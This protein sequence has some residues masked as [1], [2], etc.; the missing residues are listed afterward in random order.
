MLNRT[1]YFDIIAKIRKAY[2][3]MAKE[4]KNY[5]GFTIGIYTSDSQEDGQIEIPYDQE[6]FDAEDY[7]VYDT[8]V[9]Y[10]CAFVPFS[11]VTYIGEI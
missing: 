6:D 4:E 10:K 8:G 3:K 1:D 9:Y 2:K 5:S 11:A 7:M